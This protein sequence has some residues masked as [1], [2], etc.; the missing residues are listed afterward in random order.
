M[1]QGAES[2]YFVC[3]GA[4]KAGTS[5]L[6]WNLYWHPD[7]NIIRQKE[8]NY[9]WPVFDRR[10]LRWGQATAGYG[11][12]RNA[13]TTLLKAIV[14]LNTRFEY[15]QYF[16]CVFMPR[17]P[18]RYMRLLTPKKGKKLGGDVCPV[19]ANASA[20]RLREYFPV[21]SKAKRFMLVRNPVERAWSQVCMRIMKQGGQDWSDENVLRQIGLG[22]MNKSQYSHT[23]DL[24]ES[25]GLPVDVFFYEE[26]VEDPE[27][28]FKKI[29][30]Y[31]GIDTV[32]E[33]PNSRVTD[34]VHKGAGVPMPE[35]VR[36]HLEHLLCEELEVFA[37]RFPNR[38][39]HAWMNDR[40]EGNQKDCAPVSGAVCN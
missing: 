18:D 25:V 32:T 31:L 3:I 27:F 34:V 40:P 23:L 9:F 11:G 33:F 16:R 35:A 12:W 7:T 36:C 4:Q 13:R 10:E 15:V 6:H 22:V 26:M 17:T 28:F 8:L 30:A 29:C 5:W 38:W 14:T 20:E 2:N 19:F 39:T 24:W 1:E 37:E 21:L